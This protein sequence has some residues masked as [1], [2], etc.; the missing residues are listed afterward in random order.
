M[1][2]LVKTLPS[3]IGANQ[4]ADWSENFRSMTRKTQA[5][6]VTT[7]LRKQDYGTVDALDAFHWRAPALDSEEDYIRDCKIW[8]TNLAA[9]IKRWNEYVNNG[10]YIFLTIQVQVEPSY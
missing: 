2:T 3:Y 1:I 6:F 4:F 7:K 8:D 9:G 10:E 5:N